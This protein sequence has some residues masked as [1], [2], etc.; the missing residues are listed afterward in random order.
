[1]SMKKYYFVAGVIA[2]TY[3][4]WEACTQYATHVRLETGGK[5]AA[6]G[7]E[8]YRKSWEQV[9]Y[10]KYSFLAEDGSVVESHKKTGKPREY[11]M[12]LKVVYDPTDPHTYQELPDFERYSI[13]LAVFF[14]LGLFAVTTFILS[15]FLNLGVKVVRAIRDDDNSS[16]GQRLVKHL[17]KAGS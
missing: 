11:Y 12:G 8:S 9:E 10:V 3:S 17:R 5:V 4:G 7:V 2:L 15:G 1:M 13:G 6:V 14:H 16:F